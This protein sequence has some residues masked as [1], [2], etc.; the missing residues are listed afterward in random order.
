MGK[1]NPD[2]KEGEVGYPL[3]ALAIDKDK[4]SQNALKW[5]IDNLLSKGQT[6]VLVHVNTKVSSCKSLSLSLS[7]S[8]SRDSSGCETVKYT[9]HQ[10][11][12]V[13]FKAMR[14]VNLMVVQ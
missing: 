5:A 14:T 3:V 12:R 8:L 9:V 1:Y 4:G 6:L 11:N 2:V 10:V 7:F 13:N